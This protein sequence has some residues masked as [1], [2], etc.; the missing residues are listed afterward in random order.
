[1]G[2][3]SNGETVTVERQASLNV[4]GS[5]GTRLA[6]EVI[7]TYE[8]PTGTTVTERGVALSSLI[9]FTTTSTSDVTVT[10]SAVT[11][12]TTGRPI[13]IMLTSDSTAPAENFIQINRNAVAED[14]AVGDLILQRD[15]S[16][17]FTNRH[18]LEIG[19]S[20][21]T[22][23]DFGLLIPPTLNYVDTP[24]AGTYTYRLRA[25]A[26]G[27]TGSSIQIVGRLVVFEL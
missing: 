18:R 16:D 15:A 4:I 26:V 9:N 13:M 21:D 11:I 5:V 17:I 23:D 22:G 7:E 12:T 1:M 10:N 25:N 8:R 14:V 19:D 20:N 27:S 2:L 24:A 6:N 3:P